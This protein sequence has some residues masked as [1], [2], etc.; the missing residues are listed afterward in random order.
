MNNDNFTPAMTIFAICMGGFVLGMFV[1]CVGE[2]LWHRHE[3]AK[4]DKE[5]E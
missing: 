3:Q 2:A 4:L 5:N 1:L